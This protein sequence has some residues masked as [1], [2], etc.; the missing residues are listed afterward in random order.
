MDPTEPGKQTILFADVVGSTELYDDLGTEAAK[1]TIAACLRLFS[2]TVEAFHGR[3]VK[4]LGDGLLCAFRSPEEAVWA[5]VRICQKF[6]KE[7]TDIRI[8]VHHGEALEEPDGDVFGD[9]VNIAARIASLAKPSE[10]LISREVGEYLPPIMHPI[11]QRVPPV[12]VKGKR[13]PLEL[14]AILKED[15]STHEQMKKAQLG[16]TMAIGA[17]SPLLSRLELRF[18]DLT[19]TLHPGEVLTLGRDPEC[20]LVVSTDHVSRRHGKIFH[21]Q[22]KFVL[23]DQSSNGTYLVPHLSKMHLLREEAILHGSGLIYLGADPDRTESEPIRYET[24]S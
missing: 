10:I 24:G 21:R 22:D 5:A 19:I 8:G 2:D 17:S 23:L 6:A 7:K 15:T 20:G 11:V 13:E 16:M 12:S 18:R 3:V 1:K 4:S 9:A 14:Y